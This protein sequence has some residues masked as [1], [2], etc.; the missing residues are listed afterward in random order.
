[1]AQASPRKTKNQHDP[2]K[3]ERQEKVKALFKQL[4][5]GIAAIQSDKDFK[6][7]L[8][9]QAAFH[10]YSPNNTLLIAMQRP[11]ATMVAGYTTWQ[12]LK[13]QVRKG[14]KGIAILWPRL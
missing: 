1:M 8:R 6:R 13:R 3:H 12:K 14:E 5:E 7:Y 4:E 10:R 9:A 11:D 2:W